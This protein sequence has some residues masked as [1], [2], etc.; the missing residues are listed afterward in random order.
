MS[1]S[2]Q[3]Y[4]TIYSDYQESL[5]WMKGLGINFSPGR[6]QNYEK[7][8]RHWKSAYKTA[9]DVQGKESFPDIVSSLYEISDF[10]D[11]H[12]SLHLVPPAE[13]KSISEKLQKG[14]NGPINSAEETSSSS[15]A[16]NY[17]FE[18]L[19]ASRCHAPAQD[20]E[21]I[22]NSVSDAGLKTDNKKYGLNVNE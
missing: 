18:A 3:S 9:S 22:F 16:R 12:N 17:I 20:V 2:T 21:A 15:K 13:L 7:T 4:E 10:I 8:I 5:I 11:I 1:I 19:V 6:T 14:V